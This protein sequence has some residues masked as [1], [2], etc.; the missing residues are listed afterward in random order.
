MI[1]FKPRRDDHRKFKEAKH[2]WL[3]PWIHTGIGSNYKGCTKLRKYLLW[4][5]RVNNSITARLEIQCHLR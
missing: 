1:T 3:T 4:A 2:L 5:D